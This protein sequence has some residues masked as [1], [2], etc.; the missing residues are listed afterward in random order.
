MSDNIRSDEDYARYLQQQEMNQ[1]GAGGNSDAAA[2]VDDAAA[3]Q[4]NAM[5]QLNMTRLSSTRYIIFCIGWCLIENLISLICLV[6]TRNQ[7]CD[8]PLQIWI[9][10]RMAYNF[11]MLPIYKRRLNR[12]PETP[13]EDRFIGWLKLLSFICFMFGQTWVFDSETCQATSPF[14]YGWSLTIMLAYYAAMLAP[15]LLLLGICLCLPCVLLIL[16]Y[17][18]PDPGASDEQINELPVIEFDPTTYKLTPEQLERGE[19]PQ[20]TDDNRPS[21]AICMEEYVLHDKLRR[22]VC[23]H[24]FHVE[25]LDRWLRVNNSCPLCRRSARGEEE[26]VRDDVRAPF[27]DSIV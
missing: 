21:C 4:R 27:V 6:V 2:N 7:Q 19:T 5:T 18:T 11:C 23:E 24:D 16:R 15:L 3:V 9:Y 1:A 10:T 17:L 25:C 13:G 8:Q 14:L 12:I 26:D 22:M 20:Y